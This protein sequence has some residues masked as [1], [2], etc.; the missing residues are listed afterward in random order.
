VGTPLQDDIVR[1]HGP[2][3]RQAKTF[4]LH[5]RRWRQRR[6]LTAEPVV[7]DYEMFSKIHECHHRQDLTIA[8]IARALGLHPRTVATWVARS[9]FEPRRERPRSSVLDPFKPRI[10]QLLYTHPYSAQEIFQRLRQEG[11]RGGMTILRVYVRGIRPTE[12][13]VCPKLHFAPSECAQV[14]WAQFG[15]LAIG[16]ASRPLMAFVMVLSYSRQIFLRFFLNA[17]MENLL[18]GHIEAFESWTGVPRI[19]VYDNLKDAVLGRQ[20]DNIRFHPTLLEFV[21]HYGYEP[22]LVA[23]ARGNERGRLERTIRYLRTNFFA[24]R[25][26]VDLNDLNVQADVWCSGLAAGR[27]CPEQNTLSVREAFADEAH[28]LLK[29]PDNP[30]P[31]LERVAPNLTYPITDDRN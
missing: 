16:R 6:C 8:Q 2:C 21:R 7:I 4:S 28:L 5:L 30:Y 13:P 14:S 18:R 29:L 27:P 3:H 31:L 11:Y 22:R 15:H 25:E 23:I 12:R 19:I 9:R 26:F 24:A 20:G 10:M 1:T 17:R